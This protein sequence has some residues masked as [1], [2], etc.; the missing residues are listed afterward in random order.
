MT[1]AGNITQQQCLYTPVS[2]E[3]PM[4]PLGFIGHKE[5]FEHR[6]LA[7][8]PSPQKQTLKLSRTEVTC[9]RV[10]MGCRPGASR[11]RPGPEWSP[12]RQQCT[13]AAQFPRDSQAPPR[14]ALHSHF[15]FWLGAQQTQGATWEVGTEV[16][17]HKPLPRARTSH[18]PALS[19]G[20]IG[21]GHR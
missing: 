10:S 1:E 15:L 21:G 20:A 7:S 19:A 9:L 5:P 6:P 11:S 18:I 2:P 4:A 14:Q 12:G 16:L 8:S 13:C 3:W 17:Q